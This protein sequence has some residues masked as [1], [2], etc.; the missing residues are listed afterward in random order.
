[1]YPVF[2][3][4]AGKA[5]RVCTCFWLSV[6]RSSLSQDLR[7]HRETCRY[8]FL[9]GC[10]LPKLFVV[11][12]SLTLLADLFDSIPLV[13]TKQDKAFP[14]IKKPAHIIQYTEV[15]VELFLLKVTVSARRLWGIPRTR[16]NYLCFSLLLYIYRAYSCFTIIEY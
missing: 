4:S 15:Y 13:V 8:M 7:E 12:D 16:I 5:G 14:G 9:I 6:P 3:T 1:M 2:V 10:I 11:G